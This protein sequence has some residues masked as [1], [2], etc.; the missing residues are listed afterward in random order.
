MP[1]GVA[2]Y[3]KGSKV[4]TFERNVMAILMLFAKDKLNHIKK[5]NEEEYKKLIDYV[6]AHA[7]LILEKGDT[8]VQSI[9]MNFLTYIANWIGKDEKVADIIFSP[10]GAIRLADAILFISVAEEVI[11][12]REKINA[13]FGKDIE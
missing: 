11:V 5:A 7:N 8:S 2:G 9:A 3:R 13:L 1:C 6:E 4:D 12:K 10:E